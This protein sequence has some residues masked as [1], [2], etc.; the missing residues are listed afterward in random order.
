MVGE[1]P[2]GTAAAYPT[3]TAASGVGQYH[4]E[5]LQ[6]VGVQSE[7]VCYVGAQQYAGQQTDK[8]SGGYTP[9]GEQGCGREQQAS[10]GQPTK[11]C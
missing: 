10:Q 5:P 7:A 2:S 6:G 11:L 9:A 3:G 8:L 4:T 1:Y